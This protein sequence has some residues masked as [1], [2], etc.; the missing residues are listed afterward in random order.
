MTI[1]TSSTKVRVLLI[2]FIVISLAIIFAFEP[3]L[4]N[5]NNYQVDGKRQISSLKMPVNITRD[6]KGMAYIKGQHTLDV[7]KAQ[8]YITAQDRLFQMHFIRTLIKGRLSEFFGE[9]ARESDITYRTLGFY[10]AANK[11]KLIL[12]E[13]TLSFLQA[14]ADGVNEYINNDKNSH[15]LEFGL[16]GLEAELW[17]ISDSIAIMYFMGWGS[18]ANMKLEVIAQML[19]DQVG[20]DKFKTIFPLNIN[21]DDPTSISLLPQQ[22][23]KN[24]SKKYGQLNFIQD[25]KLNSL[26][27]N[28]W[29]AI[30]LGSNNWVV[31]SKQSPGGKPIVVNDPHLN[32]QILPTTWYPSGLFTPE[33]RA[34]GVTVPGIPG[35]LLGRNEYIGIGVTNAYG[36]SQDLYIETIDPNN[37]NNYLEGTTSIP[38]GTLDQDL[39]IKDQTEQDGFRTEKVQ[40]RLTKRGPVVSGVLKG[41]TNEKVVTVR[42]SA[43]ESMT[44]SLGI[45][46]VFTSKS[47]DDV[48]QA[49]KH[50]SIISLNYVFAD[51][52][53]DIAFQTTGRVPIRIK[54]NGSVPFEVTD[55][56]DDWS[57]WIPFDKMPQNYQ[58]QRGWLGTANHKVITEEYP[59]YYSSWFAPSYRYQRIIELLDS[60]GQ[61]TVDDHWDFMRDDLNV[62]ARSI[63]PIIAN[64]L[65]AQNETKR[66]AEILNTWDFKESIDSAAASI[67]QETYRN[68]VSLIFNDELGDEVG[69]FLLAKNY[70]WQERV[71]QW[72]KTGKSEWF[73][74]VTTPDK[75]ETLTE[76]IQ[77]AGLKT[78]KDLSERLGNNPDDWL[79]GKIHQ[80]EFL[81]PLRREG[82]GKHW[83]GGGIHSMAGSGDTLYRA[84]FPM[85][86]KGN[87]VK[88]S[89]SARMVMDLSDSEKVVAVIPGGVTGRT[90][91][92]HFTDQIEA[93]MSGDKHYWWFS[94]EKIKQYAKSEMVLVP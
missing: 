45:D 44:S 32:T 78:K 91:S 87:T 59:Y 52:H 66:M 93:F 75:T 36:D 39:K 3:I 25:L 23:S 26:R 57:G 34:V 20:Y 8:G 85:D 58:S 86:V 9:E 72:I 21:P 67:Y 15:H 14:Y 73:D 29:E 16:T 80:I 92:P 17:E 77:K 46:S 64:I 70:F 55:G 76:L 94:D 28:G 54:G 40:I 7:I 38:F 35:L 47:V 89:A 30:Q 18:A 41:L 62:S 10:R 63:S 90:F 5:L 82:L 53:G 60:P 22:L 83:L 50:N 19:I 51:V 56:I 68:L 1:P 65:L 61:K 42:W 69:S 33:F 74:D 13:Q 48:K 49:L 6:E 81:N 84:L 24:L 79:W 27:L 88:Y 37:T 71:G 12:N 31:G 2:G 11:H 4:S 43:L